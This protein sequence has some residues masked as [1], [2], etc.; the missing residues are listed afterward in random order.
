MARNLKLID[1]VIALHQIADLVAEETTD[2]LLAVNIRQC[3]DDLHQIS[4]VDSRVSDLIEKVK[5]DDI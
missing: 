3:A 1:A 5:R 4:I 2:K